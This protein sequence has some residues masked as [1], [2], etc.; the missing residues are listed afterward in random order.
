MDFAHAKSINKYK[1]ICCGIYDP[2]AVL[3][4]ANVL[5]GHLLFLISMMVYYWIAWHTRHE[6][7][8]HH[9]NTADS[10]NGP[11]VLI[12]YCNNPYN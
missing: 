12:N 6:G 10:K 3:K 9:N 1:G 7:T 8:K 5:N 11:L 4:R 2:Y